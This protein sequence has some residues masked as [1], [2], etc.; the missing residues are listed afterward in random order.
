DGQPVATFTPEK[1][2]TGPVTSQS[3]T[4]T[5]AN[6]LT[7][8]GTLEVAITAPP[9]AE[10]ASETINPN[11]TATLRPETTPGN[12]PLTSVTFDNGETSTTVPGEGV[13][14]IELVD[15]E[16]VATFT[17]EKDYT[18]PVTEQSYTVT[19]ENGL[20]ATSTLNVDITTPVVPTTPP[21]TDTPE[22]TPSE[23]ATPAPSSPS[24]TS[25][26][27][28]TVATP[29]QGSDDTSSAAGLAST[30]AGTGVLLGA[31]FAAAAVL[32]GLLVRRRASRTE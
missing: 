8:S 14:S 31:L 3:Y 11:T 26:V 4:V 23:P 32:G 12:S 16:V 15:G 1:D 18:G 9:A 10:P 25:S 22:P 24:T 6:E 27:P 13:W 17:P 19:D 21:A 20:T 28:T 5:D 30:G 7:A 29:G 2:Y